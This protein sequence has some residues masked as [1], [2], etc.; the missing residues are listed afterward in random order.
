MNLDLR[1]LGHVLSVARTRSFSRAAKQLS[2]TQPALSR[3]IASLEADLEVRLFDRG[4]GGVVITPAGKALIKEAE[5]LVSRARALEQSAA[6]WRN[7]QTESVSFGLGPLPASIVL[8]RLL[9]Q[10]TRTHARLVTNVSVCGVDDLIAGL[11]SDKIEFG[12]CAEQAVPA[13]KRLSIEVIGTI[14]LGLFV[15][16]DHPLLGKNPNRQDLERFSIASGS[17][18]T[19]QS[20]DDWMSKSYTPSIFCDNY[21]ILKEVMLSSDAI[22]LG[23]STLLINELQDGRA[24]ALDVDVPEASLGITFCAVRMANRTRSQTSELVLKSFTDL[25]RMDSKNAASP[26]KRQTRK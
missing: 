22:L 16:A 6:Q 9:A 8:P 12:I 10:L 23:S 20:L 5:Q 4:R 14:P 19:W 2:I 18:P 13:L 24:V 3:S 1:R 17:L 26:R 7:G 11:E 25:V 21:H 15:R